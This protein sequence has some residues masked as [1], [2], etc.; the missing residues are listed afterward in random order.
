MVK[1]IAESIDSSKVNVS[2]DVTG[3]F[4]TTGIAIDPVLAVTLKKPD[5]VITDMKTNT[6]D[7]CV[8]TT[9]HKTNIS[10]N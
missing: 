6:G 5:I 8:V 10:K 1:F 9:G 2:A 4:T 7:T 3:Y